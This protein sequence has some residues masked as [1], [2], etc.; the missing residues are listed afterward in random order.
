MVELGRLVMADV[1][2]KEVEVRVAI[3]DDVFSL[4]PPDVLAVA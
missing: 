2:G 1:L 4:T 3:E